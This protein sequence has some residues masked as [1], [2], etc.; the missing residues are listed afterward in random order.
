VAFGW[1]RRH[2][3]GSALVER[4]LM[5]LVE[6][7]LDRIRARGA[8]PNDPA[9]D[10]LEHDLDVRLAV[11]RRLAEGPLLARETVDAWIAED[12]VVWRRLERLQGG[13]GQIL[14]LKAKGVVLGYNGLA[15]LI[16]LGDDPPSRLAADL[17][18][19]ALEL[20]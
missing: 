8:P 6:Q 4:E 5:R 18:R 11:A 1:E 2:A 12:A 19:A 9:L 17:V 15:E 7:F 14:R 20:I 13:C 16:D 3:G 10:R